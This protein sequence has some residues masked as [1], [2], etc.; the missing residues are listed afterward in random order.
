MTDLINIFANL[1]DCHGSIKIPGIMDS[2]RSVT[3]E[4]KKMYESIEFDVVRAET[5]MLH[6]VYSY[7]PKHL[8]VLYLYFFLG[9]FV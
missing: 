6:I 7:M 2:V 8:Y 5:S 3:D 4:E 1:V 9:S